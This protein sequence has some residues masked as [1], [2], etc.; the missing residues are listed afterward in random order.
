MRE[1]VAHYLECNDDDAFH[2]LRELG[3]EALPVLIE[4]FQSRRDPSQ[5]A[6]I[7]QVVSQHR[8]VE[9]VEFLA[10]ALFDPGPEVWKHALDGLVAISNGD[11]A[12]TVA[13]ALEAVRQRPTANGLSE[14]WLIEALE[15]IRSGYL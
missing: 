3:P 14:E 15:Q 11:A 13:A 4:E 2:G 7:I 12:Q 1:A 10:A 6:L 9:S 8:L 5:R